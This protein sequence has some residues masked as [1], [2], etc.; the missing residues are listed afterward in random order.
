MSKIQCVTPV[1]GSVYVER[2]TADAAQIGAVLAAA[3]NA[4]RGWRDTPINERQA[5]CGRA[6]DAFVAESD[7]IAAELSWQMGRPVAQ[8][9]GEVGGFEERARHVISIADS[10]LANLDPGPKEGF[11]R[12]IRREPLGVGQP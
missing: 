10:A 11:T 9:P 3:D 6:V 12:Y 8:A 5:I 7:A 1:D 2:V 4:S